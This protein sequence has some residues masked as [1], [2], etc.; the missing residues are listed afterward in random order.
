VVAQGGGEYLEEQKKDKGV[1]NGERDATNR[2]KF[3]HPQNI[4]L[5]VWLLLLLSVG[6]RHPTLFSRVINF[7]SGVINEPI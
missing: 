1:V 6:G 7:K 5:G 4:I 3:E 2:S